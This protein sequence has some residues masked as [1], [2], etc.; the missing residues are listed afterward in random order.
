MHQGNARPIP[1]S[2]HLT[3][4]NFFQSPSLGRG[5]CRGNCQRPDFFLI[6]ILR[7]VRPCSYKGGS[8]GIR[9]TSTLGC[10]VGKTPIPCRASLLLF[11]EYNVPGDP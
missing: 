9:Y 3:F 2:F 7:T 4:L 10:S 6:C 1:R 11:P 5:W 8:Y